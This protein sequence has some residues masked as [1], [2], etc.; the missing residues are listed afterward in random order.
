MRRESLS[1]RFRRRAVASASIGMWLAALSMLVW[2][3]WSGAETRTA[4]RLATYRAVRVAELRGSLAYLNEW[5]TMSAQMAAA[6]GSEQWISRFEEASPRLTATVEEALAIATPEVAAALVST[7]EESHRGLLE[8]QQAAFR[9]IEASDQPSAK[10]LLDS[11]E[12]HYLQAVYQS[13]IDDFGADLTALAAARADSL[14]HRA[15]LEALGLAL[16]IVMVVAFAV[17]KR[18]NARLSIAL[19]NTE[20]IARTDPLT[21]LPNRRKLF[22]ELRSLMAGAG[23][24]QANFAL[25]LLDLDRFKS[26]NDA[27]GHPFGDELLQCVSAR[28]HSVARAGD[29]VARL[30]GD[31]FAIIAPFSSAHPDVNVDAISQ[32]G[33]QVLAALAAPFKLRHA[34]SAQIGAS[35]GIAVGEP[36][37]GSADDLLHRADVA[38][39]R[40]KVGGGN[41]FCFFEEQIDE[42]A[43]ARARL[44][45]DLRK[46]IQD[47]ALVPHY[48]PLVNL[49]TGQVVAFEML[50]RW[51]TPDGRFISPAVFIPIAESAGLIAPLTKQLMRKAC[52][53]AAA[54]PS[55]ITIACNI[56][57]L[58]L[59]DSSFVAV[60]RDLITQTGL[61][62]DRLELEITESALLDDLAVAGASLREL[63]AFGVSL[64]LDDFGTGY[65][66][67]RH[68][69]SLPFDKL[70]IDAGFVG[71][72][73]TDVESRKI[74]AAVIGLGQSLGLLTVAEGVENEQVAAL[75]HELGCDLGQGWLFGRPSPE[76]VAA[77]VLQRV[78]LADAP[79]G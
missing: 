9:L 79:A 69:R 47:D 24:T 76:A 62:A 75:V 38:L 44:E 56:S 13:G 51:P 10:A 23:N 77:A 65:S 37:R 31:E 3:A 66:S 17:A 18:G 34:L 29:M 39:Y 48:Q 4:L 70:K 42:Q 33:A 11:A 72:M 63:K 64:A 7:T 16:G 28:L 35:I 27:H 30:G 52:S 20:V 61:P 55:H 40:A 36:G 45:A 2:V 46:A 43:L 59:R 15:W 74:V 1:L 78:H 50:A 6:T 14:D 53:A 8:M 58:L 54:W 57:P 19:A 49:Q 60:L 22:E 26:V 41:R 32:L 5:L 21:A 68:L 73:A 67:L 71:A 12:Y 25:L